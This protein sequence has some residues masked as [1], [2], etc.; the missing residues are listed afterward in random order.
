MDQIK[1]GKFIAERRKDLNLT[2]ANLAKQL[3]ITDRAVSKW[4]NGKSLPDYSL[5]L[6]LCE[7]LKITVNDLFCGEV[8]SM[9]NYNKQLENNL[10]EMIEQKQKAD[11]RLLALEWVIGILSIII[12]LGFNAVAAYFPMKEWLKVV[13]VSCSM[14]ITLTGAAFSIRI[15]QIAG[16]YECQKCGH[17]YIPSYKN[18]FLAPHIN[19]TRYMKCPECN[20]KSW[21]KKVLTKK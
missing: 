10:L 9:E 16:Y 1:I 12:L 20:Q 4:E 2:Q 5:I 19:R 15:E 18:V 11:K 3:N 7:I 21:N 8:L 17:R 13:I 6:A 14:I